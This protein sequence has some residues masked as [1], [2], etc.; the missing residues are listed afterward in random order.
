MKNRQPKLTVN[1]SIDFRIGLVI[2][3]YDSCVDIWFSYK[4]CGILQGC[5]ASVL[6]DGS[7]VEKLGAPNANSLRGF[8][9]IDDA[10]SR[11]EAVC[12]GVVSCADIVSFAARDAIVLGGG[13]IPF[14]LWLGGRKDGS[15]SVSSET[16]TEL[17]APFLNYAQLVTAFANKGLSQYEMITL[18]GKQ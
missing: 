14:G 12:P 11:I 6:L 8:E 10:K 15:V 17:P 7:D 13:S 3:V 16:L 1:L 2:W 5:D 9:I 18:S 4:S